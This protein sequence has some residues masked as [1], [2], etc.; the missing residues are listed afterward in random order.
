MS[1]FVRKSVSR[2]L[3]AILASGGVVYAE[4][5]PVAGESSVQASSD[6]AEENTKEENDSSKK[7]RMRVIKTVNN[8]GKKETTD[9]EINDPEE[10]DKVIREMNLRSLF[11]GYRLSSLDRI[12]YNRLWNDFLIDGFLFDDFGF[13]RF[14]RMFDRIGRDIY[15]DLFIFSLLDNKDAEKKIKPDQDNKNETT[16]DSG[17]D[18]K[19][20]EISAASSASTENSDSSATKEV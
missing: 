15:R 6:R 10:C 17:S 14:D 16:A 11:D 7:Y 8:N 5:L 3:A 1:N 19:S 9:C 4:S 12:S 13:G 18:S 20:P 2:L